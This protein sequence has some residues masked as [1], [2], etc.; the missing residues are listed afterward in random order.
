M[1]SFGDRLND[2]MTPSDILFQRAILASL[3]VFTLAGAI[4]FRF[5]G[6]RALAA[7]GRFLPMIGAACVAAPIV[8][9]LALVAKVLLYILGGGALFVCVH[10]LILTRRMKAHFRGKQSAR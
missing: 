3:L 6:S 10:A 2:A 9:E 4:Y 7:V 1:V 5:G 8:F